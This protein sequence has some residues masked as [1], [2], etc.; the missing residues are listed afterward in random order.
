MSGAVDQAEYWARVEELLHDALQLEPVARLSFLDAIVDPKTRWEVESL[1]S[2]GGEERGR[3]LEDA[4]QNTIAD[5]ASEFSLEGQVFGAYEILH[6]LATGGMAEVYLARDPRLAREVALKLLHRGFQ[7]DDQHLIRFEKEAKAA[8]A[9]NHPNILTIYEIGQ[10]NGQTYIA[11]EYVKGVPL[12]AYTDG[13]LLPLPE[14]LRIVEQVASALVAAHQAGIVH[15]DI[16]PGNVMLR[17]DGLVKVLDFGLART[18]PALDVAPTTSSSAPMTI[19]G[20]VLG[21]PRYMSPEQARGRSVDARSDLWSLG[22]LMYEL[23]TGKPAFP[24]NETVDVLIAVLQSQPTPIAEFQK[25]PPRVESVVFKLLEKDPAKRYQTAQELLSDVRGVLERHPG[26]SRSRTHGP[27]PRLLSKTNAWLLAA[28]V[29]LL[30]AALTYVWRPPPKQHL[31]TYS[32]TAQILSGNHAGEAQQVSAQQVLGKDSRFYLNLSTEEEG[33]FYLLGEHASQGG[34]LYTLLFPLPSINH[35]SA[36]TTPG[37]L[38]K[39]GWYRFSPEPGREKLWLVWGK[40]AIPQLE[41]LRAYLNPRDKGAVTDSVQQ[42]AV[43]ELLQRASLR[44]PSTSSGE[45]GEKILVRGSANIL[46]TSL[47]VSHQ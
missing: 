3:E 25:I 46:I 17:P 36:H 18:D 45:K 32:L 28:T 42:A 14:V 33:F 5:A 24:G 40:L 21:T 13:T 16:K 10:S 8:S 44:A 31:L 35:G 41:A 11:T 1:L 29:V 34:A 12:S 38:L 22:A 23:L 30:I 39:T 6:L 9:L 26:V 19:P 15:R 4:V 7:A 37:Q 43:T 20:T 27:G 2:A 47:D